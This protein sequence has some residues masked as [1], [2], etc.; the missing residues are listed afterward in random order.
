LAFSKVDNSKEAEEQL[1]K[2]NEIINFGHQKNRVHLGAAFVPKETNLN[3]STILRGTDIALGEAKKANKDPN[4]TQE[5][6]PQLLIFEKGDET[7]ATINREVVDP[8]RFN[9]EKAAFPDRI[10]TEDAITALREGTSPADWSLMVV[11]P[12]NMKKINAEK[13]MT[14]GDQALIKLAE[15]IISIL[16]EI[17][18]E[19]VKIYRFP[20]AKPVVLA[21][22]PVHPPRAGELLIS[23]SS[24]ATSRGFH[25]S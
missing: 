24:T 12:K 4:S 6:N 22:R 15:K 2:L 20:R 13:G 5:S 16:G 8:D 3:P 11:S 21:F 1:K 18:G 9:I 7:R 17:P 23:A 19:K 14:G 10:I 25:L